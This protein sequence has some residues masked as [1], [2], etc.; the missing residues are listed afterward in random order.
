MDHQSTFRRELATLLAEIN[1]LGNSDK[2]AK[3][4][5]IKAMV[6]DKATQRRKFMVNPKQYD[7]ED[8]AVEIEFNGWIKRVEI[9]NPSIRKVKK[10][11]DDMLAVRKKYE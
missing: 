7:W 6:V 3:L 5:M 10:I 11:L 1:I 9:P 8:L 2:Y 4:K